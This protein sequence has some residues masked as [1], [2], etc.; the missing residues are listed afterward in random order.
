MP[1]VIDSLIVE[2]GLNTAKYEAG[3][4]K[5]QAALDEMQQAT[6]EAG[7]A[8]RLNLGQGG[9]AV[10]TFGKRVGANTSTVSEAAGADRRRLQHAA[11][12]RDGGRQRHHPEPAQHRQPSDQNR[13]GIGGRAAVRLPASFRR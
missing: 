6:A 1:T 9:E 12:A 10:E 11:E 13:Q 4:A 8:I 3:T 5:A 2:L 7:A